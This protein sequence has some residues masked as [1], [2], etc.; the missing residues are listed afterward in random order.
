[1]QYMLPMH[2]YSPP[3]PFLIDQ[4]PDLVQKRM[5]DSRCITTNPPPFKPPIGFKKSRRKKEN[6]PLFPFSHSTNI[7]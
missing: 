5:H 3:V 7:I 2:V 6:K 4:A 1:M